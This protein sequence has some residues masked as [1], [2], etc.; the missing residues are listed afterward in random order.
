MENEIIQKNKEIIKNL[1]IV[2]SPNK[3]SSLEKYLGKDYKVLASVGHIVKLPYTGK[4]GFGT[5]PGKW[6]PEWKIDPIKRKIVNNLKSA[7]KKSKNIFIATDPDREGEAIGKNLVD[8]LNIKSKYKRIR[9]NEITEEA[10]IRS[11]ENPTLIDENLVN[12]QIARRILD[13]IIGFQLSSLLRKKISNSPM[14]PS[15]GRVQSIALKFIIEKEKKI[16]AFVPYKY[17]KVQGLINENIVANLYNKDKKENKEWIDVSEINKIKAK[18]TDYLKIKDIKIS[19]KNEAKKNPLKLSTLYTK[20]FSSFGM[21]AAAVRN[22]TQRLYEGYG[23]GGLIS[24]PRTDSTRLSDI[25]VKKGKLFLNKK[26]GNEFI[27]ENIKGTSGKQDAHEAI[28]PTDPNLEPE[29]AKIKFNL[30]PSEYNVY[31]LI[32]QITLACLMKAPRREFIR[33]ILTNENNLLF[34]LSSSKVIFEGYLK[35]IWLSKK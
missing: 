4:Y 15:A 3:I 11:L 25:F 16:E 20:C 24:Y 8:F 32:Y 28:R 6:I 33:Y 23:D 13:R 12:A 34:K 29:L 31:K 17:F 1:V 7:V 5:E 19:Q 21:S 10:V 22:A 2:E 27:E 30:N 35:N 26:F 9:F 14:K 18:L